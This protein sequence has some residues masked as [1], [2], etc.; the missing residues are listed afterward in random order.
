M[1]PTETPGGSRVERKKEETKQKI[2]AVAMN[3]F[4]QQGFDATTMELIANEVDIAK[5]TLYNYFPV[6]EAII[7][8]Y[9]KRSFQEQNSERTLRLRKLPDTRSRLTLFFNELIEGVKTSKEI[10]EKY[11]VYRMQLLVSVHQDD[12]EKSG[13]YLAATEIID[14]GKNS[15]EVRKDLP[16]YVLV[17]LFEFA[18]IEAVKQFYFDP[19]KF[20]APVVI[21]RYVDL[22]LN[23]IRK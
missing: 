14:L 3:L 11:I 5:G 15:G 7:D 8:E 6:K 1:S 17:E 4:K 21:E 16:L 12:T 19:E 23:G 13:F 9:I 20:E 2:L 10:F 22:C 18:F